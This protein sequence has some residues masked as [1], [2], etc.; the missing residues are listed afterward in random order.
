[1]RLKFGSV[2]LGALLVAAAVATSAAAKDS[3]SDLARS[4]ERAALTAQADAQAQGLTRGQTEGRVGA[5]ISQV[6]IDSGATPE[7]ALLALNTTSTSLTAKGQAT[8]AVKGAISVVGK[9]ITTAPGDAA[10][11]V[12]RPPKPDRPGRGNPDYRP[13][14]S[15]GNAFL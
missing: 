6:I 3:A 11:W 12:V 13:R 10:P 8:P 1:M 5:A 4:V 7:A 15:R 14:G 2:A 9:V